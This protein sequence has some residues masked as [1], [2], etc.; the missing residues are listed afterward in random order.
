MNVYGELLRAQ[1]H[2]SASDLT[3]TATGLVYFNTTTGPKWYNGSAWLLAAD[4]T[5]SQVFTNKDY[6]GGT[7]SNTSRVT[8]PKNTTSNLNGLTRKE[9]TLVYDTDADTV[10]Y[11]NG[12]SL[13]TLATTSSLSDSPLTANNY[14]IAAGVAANALTISLKTKAGTDPTVSDVASFSFRDATLTSG[15][16]T[17]VNVTSALS[18]VISS[19][20]TLGGRDAQ[21]HYIY[22]YLIN[23][24][25][26]G[27]IAY[28]ATKYGD[29]TVISTTAEGGAGGADSAT[30]IY[31]TTAR[32]NVP[33]RRIGRILS[34]QT[35]VGTWAAAVTEI[36][37]SPVIQDVAL[38]SVKAVQTNGYGSTSTKIRRY[39]NTTTVGTCLTG[40]DSVAN[41]YT[42]TVNE[43]GI[44]CIS[45]Y[46]TFDTAGEAGLSL[47]SSQGTTAIGGITASDIL[48]NATTSAGG[49][50]EFLSVTTAL[51]TN[52]IIRCHTDGAT[53]STARCFL[54]VE[55]I[56]KL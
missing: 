20:S 4:T 56:S 17:T 54:K 53:G 45:C 47:N 21:P 13:L 34:T 3:P 26:A 5:T 52:D 2:L 40:A 48:A 38:G 46:D 41:G 44:Y 51:K 14:S 42:I 25:G 27:E 28:S 50:F 22:V 30:A 15:V 10:R 8:L 32:T 16:Y 19:G 35:T 7:A 37:S 29:G 18:T 9:G 11:D 55:Q 49:H 23:N 6:D 31:S 36:T 39:I 24:A 1:L 12:A 33:V 43:P